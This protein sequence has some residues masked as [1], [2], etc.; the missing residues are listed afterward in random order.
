MENSNVIHF[1]RS[2]LF[3]MLLVTFANGVGTEN[4]QR[5]EPTWESLDR[6]PLP[7]WYD[8]AKFGILMHWGLYS[9]PSFGSEW[10]WYLWQGEKKASYINYMEKNYRPGFS[11]A[12]FAPM[13]T[14]E[15]F[16]PNEFAELV[17]NS[18]A[19]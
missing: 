2:V 14:A 11:Y 3:T 12:D 6:R 19:R 13:F 8:E 16:N 10:F 5:Y 15:F 1:Q 9:V 17:S 7:A 4:A 18:G